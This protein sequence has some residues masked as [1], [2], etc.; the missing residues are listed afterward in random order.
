MPPAD[1]FSHLPQNWVGLF[2]VL[3]FLVYMAAQIIEKFPGIAKHI[4]L[5]TWWHN[6]QKKQ[7]KRQAWVA[8]DNEVITA[9]QEQV[10]TIAA[11]LAKVNERVRVFTSWSVY[12]ARY[13]HRIEVSH[14][15]C[16]DCTLPKHYDFFEYEKLWKL[17][18]VAA[19]TL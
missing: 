18:P 12:D 8:E 17:D 9:L 15:E 4:P 14:A 10:S 2:A 5:G 16:E 13:H 7:N 6:R 11:D 19:A 3:T 1:I